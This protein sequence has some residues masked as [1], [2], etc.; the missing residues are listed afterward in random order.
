MKTALFF[1]LNWRFNI[2]FSRIYMQF[3][4]GTKYETVPF[5]TAYLFHISH[6]FVCLLSMIN[7]VT[8][9]YG[10]L[11]VT[12]C[13]GG[14]GFWAEP[15]CTLPRVLAGVFARQVLWAP[16]GSCSVHQKRCRQP[17]WYISSFISL[18]SIL[19]RMADHFPSVGLAYGSLLFYEI[20]NLFLSQQLA[21]FV[22][23][24]TLE[25]KHSHRYEANKG[26]I[27]QACVKHNNFTRCSVIC[28]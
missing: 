28:S 17:K 19:G 27:L 9:W 6:S 8:V 25:I 26:I 18:F 14:S 7:A 3:V 1:V 16:V 22:L 24:I 4:L 5:E 2:G 13:S 21:I 20:F 11:L 12:R 23:R 15:A 10:T